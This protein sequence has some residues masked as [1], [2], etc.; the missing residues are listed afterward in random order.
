MTRELT[1][2]VLKDRPKRTSNNVRNRLS[3]T[4]KDPNFEYRIVTDRDDRI[5]ILKELGYEVC[6]AEEVA[7]GDKRVDLGRSIGSVA[8]LTLGGGD[9]GVVMKIPKEWYEAD[10]VTKAKVVDNTEQTMKEDARKAGNYGN[11]EI[12]RG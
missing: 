9:K 8:S 12:T 2:K 1:P 11:I 10:R 5:E 6:T 7:V 3:V 4:K